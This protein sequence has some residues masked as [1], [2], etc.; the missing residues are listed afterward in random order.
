MA[1]QITLIDYAERG[2]AL[3]IQ[4]EV[5]DAGQEKHFRE[6]VR[7]LGDLLYGELVHPEKSPLTEN[8]RLHVISYLKT[9]FNR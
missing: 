8:C 3:Y 1:H 9:H 5:F 4:T 6:E 2:T 7:F